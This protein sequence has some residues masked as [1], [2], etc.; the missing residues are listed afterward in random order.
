MY[1]ISVYFDDELSVKLQRYINHIAQKTGNTFMIDNNVPP[2][3]TIS[4]IEAR[5]VEVLIP[6]MESLRGKLQSGSVQFV[7]VG[8]LFPYVLYA[9][10][11][12]NEYLQDMSNTIYNA[13]KDIP[14]TQISRFY[15]PASWLPHVT[16][17]KTLDKQQML[18]AFQVMQDEFIPIEG[19]IIGIGLAKTNPHEDV[20]YFAI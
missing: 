13:F 7:S 11:V 10:P 5:D 17:S 3:M 18:T 12:L 4:S 2:H 19:H 14:E 16:L 1:L 8:A 9:T 15:K 6:Y 20:V